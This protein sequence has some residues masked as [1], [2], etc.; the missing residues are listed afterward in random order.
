MKRGRP[1]PL[2][3]RELKKQQ[4]VVVQ[5]NKERGRAPFIYYNLDVV[6]NTD[7]PVPFDV[8]QKPGDI[9]SENADKNYCVGIFRFVISGLTIPLMILYPETYQ[10][11]IEDPMGIQHSAYLEYQAYDKQYGVNSVFYYQELAEYVTTA[12]AAAMA[13]FGGGAVDPPSMNFFQTLGTFGVEMPYDDFRNG[14][15]GW[16]VYFNTRLWGLFGNIKSINV[17]NGL[18]QIDGYANKL[19]TNPTTQGGVSPY[20]AADNFVSMQEYQ[21]LFRIQEFTRIVLRSTKLGIQSEYAPGP[22]VSDSLIDVQTASGTGNTDAMLT[23]LI[24]Y[25]DDAAGIRGYI[26]YA[27]EKPRWIPIQKGR[28]NEIDL[29]VSIKDRKGAEIPYYVP[30]H[31]IGALKIGFGEMDFIN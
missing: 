19:N 7:N 27:V 6:N 16:K 11:V 29:R 26:Y 4:T 31:Q 3:D 23:D 8:I 21:A 1:D 28:I 18:Y 13:L 10:V 30:A 24:P 15:T 5:S 22:N 9:I 20:A 25:L 17:G 14:G 2:G 12:M